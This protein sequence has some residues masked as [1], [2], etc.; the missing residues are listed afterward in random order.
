MRWS[1]YADFP[2]LDEPTCILDSEFISILHRCCDIMPIDL[3][4]KVVRLSN[5]ARNRFFDWCFDSPKTPWS[6]NRL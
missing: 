6:E 3:E 5:S 1:Y 2:T 4:M